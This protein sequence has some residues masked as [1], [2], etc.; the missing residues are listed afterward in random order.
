MT[1]RREAVRHDPL[2][3]TLQE[4]NMPKLFSGR[5]QRHQR[6]LDR[7]PSIEL[8]ES[9]CLMPA[10]VPA[11][12]QRHAAG[13]LPRENILAAPGA[14]RCWPRAKRDEPLEARAE[15]LAVIRRFAPC[16]IQGA[17]YLRRP[18]TGRQHPHDVAIA[19][20]L[21]GKELL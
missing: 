8:Y 2:V 13:R 6:L 21:L 16:E 1:G 20:G 12:R 15:P 14:D 19:H 11:E 7:L 10:K 18:L 4:P 5:H 17:C 9:A 3:G